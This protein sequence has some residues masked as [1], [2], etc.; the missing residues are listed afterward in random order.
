LYKAAS[1][2][3]TWAEISGKPT[4]LAGYGITNAMST[5]H[6]A[7]AITNTNI[8]NWNT[9]FGWGNHATAG[10]VTQT[11]LASNSVPRWTGSQLG[12][13]PINASATA[14]GINSA[15][16]STNNLNVVRDLA[17]GRA[18]SADVTF[19]G[20]NDVR[21][22]YGNSVTNP[23]WGIGGEFIGGFKGVI[24]R[25][26][27]SEYSGETRALEAIASGTTGAGARIAVYGSAFGGSTNWAG[28]FIGNE[29]ISGDLLVGTLNGATGYKVSVNG[30]IMCT[31]LRVLAVANW[32]DYV[33]GD[34]HKRLSLDELG[35]FVKT[36]KHLP[37]VPSA[38]EMEAAQGFEVGEMQK[39][40][41]E[42]VEELTLYILEQHERIK[43]QDEA[44][45]EQEARLKKQEQDI[46]NLKALV[47]QLLND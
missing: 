29:Y 9:A 3:P 25:A 36:E 30:K 41:I 1:Y 8:T 34:S 40:T 44:A 17:G 38:A 11:G 22:V 2:V 7:N 15:P 6:P 19:S 14:V 24:A 33:F 18:I 27:S 10:Y 45:K 16:V 20:N 42:K 23:G 5:A 21:A 4:T 46:E 12:V 37:G 39:I 31:E 35:T 43:A 26:N 32:P 28:Y 13:S 47:Q